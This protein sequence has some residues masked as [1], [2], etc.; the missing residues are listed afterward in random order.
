MTEQFRI[1]VA[2]RNRHVREFLQRE[3]G[4]EGFWVEI[5]ADGREVLAR[6]EVEPLPDL[7]VLDLELPFVEGCELARRLKEMGIGIPVV[8]HSFP[9][10]STLPCRME[11][12]GPFVEKSGE[13]IQ[14][15]REI[16]WGSLRQAYPGRFQARGGEGHQEEARGAR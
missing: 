14:G 5:A 15:L 7:M 9:P 11:E 13:N 10:Q 4:A 2:D 16:I 3:L 8:V 12:I 6:M 1:L